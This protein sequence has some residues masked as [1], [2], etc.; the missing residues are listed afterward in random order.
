[1]W[2][3][4]RNTADLDDDDHTSQRTIIPVTKGRGFNSMIT[5]GMGERWNEKVRSEFELEDLDRYPICMQCW[6]V[7]DP[8]WPNKMQHQWEFGACK[9]TGECCAAESG[10]FCSETCLLSH[11]NG[12]TPEPMPKYVEAF[13]Q[14]RRQCQIR[15]IML[16]DLVKES[17]AESKQEALGT[18]RDAKSEK[19]HQREEETTDG[20]E[21]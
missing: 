8:D 16:H 15:D 5:D 21:G 3:A 19:G 11:Q 20:S 1:M 17:A 18:A 6:C 4:G 14:A 12:D 10:I 2:A 7:D 9:C 13:Q